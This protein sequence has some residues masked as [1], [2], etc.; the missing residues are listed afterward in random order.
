MK[1]QGLSDQEVQSSREKYGSNAI[2]ESEP[3]TFWEAFKETFG[4]CR[5]HDHTVFPGVRGDL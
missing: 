5:H 2:P 1:F 3:T 4:D